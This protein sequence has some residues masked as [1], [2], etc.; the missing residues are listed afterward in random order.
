MAKFFEA[1][2]KVVGLQINRAVLRQKNEW[3]ATSIPVYFQL[4]RPKTDVN[5]QHVEFEESI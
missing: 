2:K 4:E 3:P 5:R 1:V